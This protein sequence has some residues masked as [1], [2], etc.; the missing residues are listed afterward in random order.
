MGLDGNWSQTE[1]AQHGRGPERNNLGDVQVV[2]ETL[3]DSLL[4]LPAEVPRTRWPTMC[5][6]R[7]E[8]PCKQEDLRRM[9]ERF[10]G[11]DSFMQSKV[12]VKGSFIEETPS[13]KWFY[14]RQPKD[15]CVQLACVLRDHEVTCSLAQRSWC[16]VGT[17]V[18]RSFSHIAL[19]RKSLMLDPD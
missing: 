2:F 15:H 18:E 16:P 12:L 5:L 4:L 10:A 8:L 11:E 19:A 13:Y 6:M 3:I 1:R 7:S 14:S 17:C 9:Q